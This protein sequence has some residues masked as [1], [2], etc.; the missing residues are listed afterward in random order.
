MKRLPI[1]IFLALL[2]PLSSGA[3]LLNTEPTI[4]IGLYSTQETVTITA[5][6]SFQVINSL[7]EVTKNKK[8][9]QTAEFNLN[10]IKKGNYKRI[11]PEDGAIIT[12]TSYENRPDW[13]EELNDNQFR[14]IIEIRKSET[15]GKIWV[16]DEL[17][18]EEYLYGIAEAGNDNDP[19]YLK[20]LL[21]AARTYALYNIQIPTKHDEENYI[22]DASA[23]DQVYRGYGAETRLPNVKAAVDA[24]RGKTITYDG[25][26]VVTPYFSSSD[27]GTRSWSEV[28]S[29]ER[30]WLQSKDDP[31]CEGSTLSGHGVGL[32]AA[33]A[34][35][36]AENEDWTWKEI[37][38]YYYTGIKIKLAY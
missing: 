24:T 16:I 30:A 18:I 7:G 9:G 35:Y 3:F 12:I 15:T 17:P 22:L 31:G 4:R 14:G 10:Q 6:K 2:S 29:G 37:L 28:W 33:G 36:F 27:G 38:Q 23:N 26:I 1:C 19:A 25:E 20:A 11:V 5:D 21:T 13:N 32:S 34:R 8:A